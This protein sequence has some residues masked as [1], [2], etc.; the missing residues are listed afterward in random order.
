M[1]ILE[2]IE[3]RVKCNGEFLAEY[4][5][6]EAVAGRNDL[7]VVKYVEAIPNAI[8]SVQLDVRPGFQYEGADALRI[9]R[10]FDDN[11]PRYYYLPWHQQRNEWSTE[12][13]LCDKSQQWKLTKFAFGSVDTVEEIDAS[14]ASVFNDPSALQKLG[15]INLIVTRGT[16][17]KLS[18]PEVLYHKA[19]ARV[20]VIPEKLLK[21]ASLTNSIDKVEEEVT[22][23]LISSHTTAPLPGS[24][25]RRLSFKFLY[26]SRGCIP[27]NPSPEAQ[28]IESESRDATGPPISGEGEAEIERLR[29]R[30]RQLEEKQSFTSAGSREGQHIKRERSTPVKREGGTE[31][32]QDS[33]KRRKVTKVPEVIDLSGD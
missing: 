28:N 32:T 23:P 24:R 7:E 17:T 33:G 6:P 12:K 30:L 22:Q 19:H 26:R 16:L 10:Q 27:R 15:T 14:D 13:Y 2:G 5:E 3:V 31:G 21:G 25:G 8:F 4:D 18:T 9:T 29:E 20:K 1:A 11:K